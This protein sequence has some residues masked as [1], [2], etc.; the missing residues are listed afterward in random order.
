MAAR[1]GDSDEAD[2]VS[3]GAWGDSPTV[4]SALKSVRRE[5]A[6]RLQLLWGS[7]G[8]SG[9]ERDMGLAEGD[10]KADREE[11]LGVP[12]C[13]WDCCTVGEKEKGLARWVREAASDGSSDGEASSPKT[14]EW[15]SAEGQ[16]A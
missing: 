9:M 7:A 13:G 5:A 8:D 6:G 2:C 3:E 14:M 11:K 15:V 1:A 4:G 10:R 12:P 16:H